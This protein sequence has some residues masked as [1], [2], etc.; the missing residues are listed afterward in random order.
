MSTKIR[1][2]IYLDRDQE[3][4]L[5]RLAAAIGSSEAEIIRH[6]LDSRLGMPKQLPRD[7]SAWEEEKQFIE[8]WIARG[9]VG[10]GRIW[11]REDL[12]DR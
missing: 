11:K 6:S 8:D 9:T 3:L 4:Q 12:Y 7:L 10:G 2:Q 5:K 1:K